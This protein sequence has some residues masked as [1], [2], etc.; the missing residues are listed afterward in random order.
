MRRVA[1][2][3]AIEPPLCHGS[4][5][6]VLR[7][8]EAGR[9]R[10]LLPGVYVAA[11]RSA[12][13]TVRATAINRWDPDAVICGRAA[14]ALSYWPEI[15]PG[16]LI[17]VASPNRHAYQRG[18]RFTQRTIPP[19]LIRTRGELRL[20]AP[21]LTAMELATY[22]FTDP[23]DIALRTRVATLD[24]LR[25]A[26]DDRAGTGATQD[27]TGTQRQISARHAGTGRLSRRLS[28]VEG[29]EGVAGSD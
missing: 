8:V 18:F 22:E 11:S 29:D 21:S 28:R 12:D 14:A 5:C 17:E 10:R 3:R 2:L 13:L 23:I 1:P 19:E 4:R 7:A 16:G 25:D 15:K 24:S 26:I 6:P 27:R 20:T 9:L